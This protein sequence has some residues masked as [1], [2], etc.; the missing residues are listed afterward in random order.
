MTTSTYLARPRTT[1]GTASGTA[2][3]ACGSSPAACGSRCWSSAA[4]LAARFITWTRAAD[5]PAYRRRV[6]GERPAGPLRER[7][8]PASG[9]LGD[10]LGVDR[11][12]VRDGRRRDHRRPRDPGR[13]A[14]RTRRGAGRGAGLRRAEA[15]AG[16]AGGLLHHHRTPVRLRRPGAAEHD[17][18]ARGRRGH[19]RGRHPAGHQTA[20]QRGR[21]VHRSQRQ[22]R[23]VAEHVQGLGARGRRHSGADVCRSQPGQRRPARGRAATRCSTRICASCCWTSRS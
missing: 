5:H 10:L 14:G 11:P 23:Q 17:R 18:R 12:A 8:A 4:L 13:L 6:P 15:R 7:Q 3:T 2:N 16:H 1:A 9:G 19:R 20:H 22:H 21:G